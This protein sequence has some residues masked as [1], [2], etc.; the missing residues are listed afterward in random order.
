MKEI[1]NGWYAN[2]SEYVEH[3]QSKLK[4]GDGTTR[5]NAEVE[6]IQLRKKVVNAQCKRISTKKVNEK[7]EAA[8]HKKPASHVFKK[9]AGMV[10]I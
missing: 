5:M 9:P 10:T 1:S 8:I 3:K 4:L 6:E 2:L 7:P